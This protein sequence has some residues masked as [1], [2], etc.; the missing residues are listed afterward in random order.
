MTVLC[1]KLFPN[2]C[3]F[4]IALGKVSICLLAFEYVVLKCYK[5]TPN[6]PRVNI[7]FFYFFK[8]LKNFF[9][10]KHAQVAGQCRGGGRE[11]ILSR[12]HAQHRV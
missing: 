6:A 8:D 1:N 10:R 4:Q 12:H 5:K 3:D 11:R 7:S 2:I 9:E